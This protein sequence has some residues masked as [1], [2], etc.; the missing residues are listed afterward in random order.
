[1]VLAGCTSKEP[2]DPSAG[3][4]TT[5]SPDKSP[6]TTSSS[7]AAGSAITDFD[8]CAE[9]EAVAGQFS[10]S[11]IEKTGKQDCSGRWGQT[12]TSVGVK[13]F[14]SLSIAEAKGQPGARFSDTTVG[15]RKAKK[16]EAGLTDTSCLIAVEVGP[17]SRVDFY[18][19]ATASV[20]ESCDAA[21][22]LAEAIEPKLPK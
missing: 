3:S 8:L 13:V 5:T 6:T 20:G 15:S 2:G 12:T 16:V 19:E 17:K 10:I 22:K 11:R 9:F 18:G 7:A 14:P 4:T 21:Q 1:M